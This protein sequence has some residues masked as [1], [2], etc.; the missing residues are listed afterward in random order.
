V[1]HSK[2]RG[3]ALR[4]AG[5][6]L[7]VLSV[8]PWAGMTSATAADGADVD[9]SAVVASEMEQTTPELA[10][11]VDEAPADEVV[12]EKP[13]DE[14]SSDEGSS[15]EGSDEGQSSDEGEGAEAPTDE[16]GE[17]ASGSGDSAE[18]DA[19]SDSEDAESKDADES[20]GEDAG[21]SAGTSTD[22]EDG[23]QADAAQ[24]CPVLP[25]SAF[26]RQWNMA[27]LASTWP[28][29]I[30]VRVTLKNANQLP[31]DCEYPV[32]AASYET[33]GLTW[34]TSGD[35]TFVDHDSATLTPANNRV[36][37]TIAAPTCMG[38]VDLYQGTA[39]HDGVANPLPR[40]PTGVYGG[41]RI[42][43]GFY[44][45]GPCAQPAG[46]IVANPCPT[47][48]SDRTATVTL[49]VSEGLGTQNFTVWSKTGA[50]DYV[51]VG[52]TTTLPDG[53]TREATVT[54][55]LPEDSVVTLQVRTDDGVLMTSAP[56]ET[57][58]V[59]PPLVPS[60]TAVAAP[61]PTDGSERVATVTLGVEDGEGPARDFTVWTKTGAGDY[62]QVGGTTTLP[63]GAGDRS[64]TVTIPLP[65]DST[66]TVQVRSGDFVYTSDAFVTD[67]VTPPV[68]APGAELGDAFCV[69]EEFGVVEVVLDNSDSEVDVTFTLTVGEG[70]ESETAEVTVPAGAVEDGVLA[71]V[72]STVETPVLVQVGDEVLLDEVVV[73]DCTDDTVPPPPGDTEAPDDTEVGGVRVPGVVTPGDTGAVGGGGQGSALPQTG[74]GDLAPLAG[75]SLVFLVAGGS[76]MALSRRR[77]PR[78]AKHVA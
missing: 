43:S 52:G 76:L 34:P 49:R 17:K 61:C 6:A 65:E 47:D 16:S 14:G 54:V 13:S 60:A 69:P 44:A 33:Q 71:A 2:T 23:A 15:D 20:A 7:L 4:A 32:S 59:T 11:A 56:F 78:Q 55:P 51:Q 39:V 42:G 63:N 48:G 50:G 18:A 66:V 10:P 36:T 40:Y 62:V 31:A 53:N 41:Q 5:A 46:E 9:T 12:E 25:A 1:S 57:D 26:E 21:K 38:Q 22:D 37:L 72:E 29:E 74:A 24:A 73:V 35:Q 58:C 28:S 75:M 64:A 77:Q 68:V 45:G 19:E 3:R 27:P 8:A 30:T 67:C 70:D